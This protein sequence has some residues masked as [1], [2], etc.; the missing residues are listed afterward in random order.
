[1]VSGRA[2]QRRALRT[3][4]E[5]FAV[6]TSDHELDALITDFI[7]ELAFHVVN[8]AILIDPQRIAVGGGLTRSWHRI[9]PRLGATLRAAV[10]YPPSLVLGRFP[11]DAPLL[12]AVALA[13]GAVNGIP[14]RQP[15]LASDIPLPDGPPGSVTGADHSHAST[16]TSN[17]A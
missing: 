7:D 11:H 6:A 14:R 4:A 2:L 9:G 3:A 12:G 10:P 13:I 15:M 1:M 8:L 17:L 16:S 5:V